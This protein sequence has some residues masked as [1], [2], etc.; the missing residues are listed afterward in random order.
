MMLTGKTFWFKAIGSPRPNKFNPDVPQWSFDLSIDEENQDKLIKAGIKKDSFKNK[1]DERGT[2]LTFTRDAVKKNG[3]AG[4][5]FRVVDAQNKDWD[6]TKNIGNG[7]ELNVV[8]SLNEREFR[9]KKFLK[10]SAVAIQVWDLV[11]YQSGGFPVKEGGESS[12]SPAAGVE[13]R[14]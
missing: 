8:V 3:E 14:W 13:G 11:E 5:P 4:K 2:F 1:D 12:P 9:G 7:S 10:P 6:Q